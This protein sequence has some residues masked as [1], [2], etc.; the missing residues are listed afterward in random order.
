MPPVYNIGTAKCLLRVY[1]FDLVTHQPTK[2]ILH[3]KVI[4][5]T[6]DRKNKKWVDIDCSDYNV[7]SGSGNFLVALEWVSEEKSD[8]REKL[9]AP[10]NAGDI[11]PCFR[12]S[13]EKEG[14][15]V[16]YYS[17]NESKWATFNFGKK[18]ENMPI[19]VVVSSW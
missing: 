2:D 1:E 17:H 14:R 15:L 4:V 5:E 12:L 19:R 3:E 6:K 13:L 11:T 9:L 10:L 8:A 16:T 18:Y 7:F